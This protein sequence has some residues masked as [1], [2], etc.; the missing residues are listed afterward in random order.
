MPT[1]SSVSWSRR[2]TAAPLLGDRPEPPHGS[3]SSRAALQGIGAN[4]GG[5]RK[6]E[7]AATFQPAQLQWAGGKRQGQMVTW[8]KH[9]SRAGGFGERTALCPAP[10]DTSLG[11]EDQRDEKQLG[12]CPAGRAGRH[13][14]AWQEVAPVPSTSSGPP[15]RAPQGRARHAAMSHPAPR[16]P[17]GVSPPVL[18]SPKET[19]SAAGSGIM[20]RG[21]VTGP[22]RKTEE[23]Q[24]IYPAERKT[25]GGKGKR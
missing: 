1:A 19:P 2:M 13:N 17:R 8:P 4:A 11:G 15:S 14:V 21:L 25:A 12:P 5:P 22:R 23:I 10:T 16:E 18:G 24:V 6:S 9:P 3:R 7:R 20:V